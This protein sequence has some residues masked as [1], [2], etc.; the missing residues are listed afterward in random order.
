MLKRIVRNFAVAN[1]CVVLPLLWIALGWM[2]DQVKIAMRGGES[3][4]CITAD[5]LVLQ[6]EALGEWKDGIVWR[7]YLREGMEWKELAFLLPEGKGVADVDRVDLQKWKLILLGKAGTELEAT[8]EWQ[9]GWRFAN[10]KF[11]RAG[12]ASRSVAGGLAGFEVVL[13]GIAWLFAVRRHDEKWKKLLPSATLTALTLT[14][15]MQV[16]LPIQSYWANQSSYPF[17]FGALA[18]AVALRF[19]WMFV[20]T[21]AAVSL[22]TRCFGRWVLGTM[23][24]FAVCVYL[25][26]GIL[27]AGLPDLN[28]DWWFFQNRTRALWDAAVWASVFV[29][30]AALHPVIKKRYGLV[31][32]C[33]SVMVGASMFDVK[34]EEQA[35]TSKLIVHDFASIE[36]VIRSV[37]YSTNRN[38][39][40]FVIDSLEREQAHAIMEDPVTGPELREKFIGFTEYLDNVGAGHNSL[41]GVANLF[42]GNYPENLDGLFDF[43]TSVYSSQSAL[44]DYLD[45]GSDVYLATEALGYG[46]CNHQDTPKG[47]GQVSVPPRGCFKTPGQDGQGW[48]LSGIARFRWLPFAA[49][50]QYAYLSERSMPEPDF[51]LH[52]WVVYP[53]LKEADIQSE[54]G[55]LVFVHTHGVHGPILYNRD[56]KRLPQVGSGDEA[57]KEIGM[58]VMRQLADLF[59]DY[60][61]KGI[62]DKSLIVVLADHGTQGDNQL[63]SETLPK[64][65]RPFLWVKPDDSRHDFKSSN[66][67]T[68]HARVSALLREASR[69]TL[70]EDEVEK[71]LQSPRR[72]YRNLHGGVGPEWE[73]WIVDD[74]GRIEHS[75]G[76]LKAGT[77]G[78]L[79]PLALARHYSLDKG[80]MVKSKVDVEFQNTMFWDTPT[81]LYD[82]PTVK[83]RFRV[84][85]A[86]K[87]Y[88]LHLVLK[89][90]NAGQE[91]EPGT[92]MMFR[93]ANRKAD[94]QRCPIDYHVTF[95]LHGL[96]PEQD[97]LV[98]IEGERETGFLSRVHFIQLMLEEER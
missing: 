55:T 4:P 98:E 63:P 64:N 7:F 86:G 35:D 82:T 84:P 72:K 97:G 90:T 56:G 96:I 78:Q 95:E 47:R 67:P 66:L 48:T 46:Y 52:E 17:V 69:K 42:T 39:L 61:E 73:D 81:L 32:V 26:S 13:L 30:F 18:R 70:S 59:D 50:A 36:T 92:C 1:I 44:L 28:G 83:F 58:F 51:N 33:L 79:R 38:V 57:C 24:A 77:S 25:E 89:Y 93:Q 22:L 16:A 88:S 6:G 94:W 54:K 21:T 45:E 71:L 76:K 15:L 49:K 8:E 5:G 40:L 29:V 65:G 41:I 60:R 85:E 10:P 20:L 37:T 43:F 23:L 91:D 80:S 12:F 11:E 9:N 87:R 27:S 14:V 75:S 62:Y 34:R 19:F 3:A 68:S 74:D 2:P 31:A 53:L